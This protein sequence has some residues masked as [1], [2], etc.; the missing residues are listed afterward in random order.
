MNSLKKIRVLIVDDSAVVRKM[1]ATALSKDP[2]IEVVGAACDP[3][4]A[5]DMIRD[6]NPDVLTLDIEMPRMDGLTFLRILQANKP[7]PVIVIS[8]LST[9]G[10]KAAMDALEA[11]AVEVLA[12]PTSAYSIGGLVDQLS[13]RVR[14]AAASRRFGFQRPTVLPRPVGSAAAMN[15]SPKATAVP[16]GSA[17]HEQQLILIGA[18]TGG[19]EALK[20]VLSKLPP[21]APPVLIAQHIPAYF[22][23]MFAER[24]D[25][26]SQID[27]REAAEGDE[28]RPGLALVA[29]GDY[30]M[31]VA[32]TGQRFRVSLNQNPP[33]HH[34][35]PSVDV[36][37]R[38]A[39]KCFGARMVVCLLTG[40]G[41]D[42]ALG[43][44]TLK[45][46]GSKTI[47]QDEATCVVYGMPR[48][49]GELGV[50]DRFVPL[51]QI[52]SAIMEAVTSMANSR[53]ASVAKQ[54]LSC[55]S[56]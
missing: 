5:R 30:H 15:Q 47:G 11:G 48:A 34:C 25:Q 44:Q 56:R 38:S 1:V 26:C 24:M 22:S 43:M 7:M 12:K 27:V 55:P 45:A 49:A 23:K 54:P 42:G 46:M 19:T 17:F 35:R 50:V 3:Y 6:L 41:T 32:W 2:M 18:S 20:E 31:T 21:N 53:G 33:V 36:L 40:M 8:S 29:P 52:S 14:A 16:T 39:S 9:A 10:S 13:L 4:V 28:L 51:P 37:F